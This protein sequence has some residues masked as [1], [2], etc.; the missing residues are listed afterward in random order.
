MKRD[1]YPNRRRPAYW[2]RRRGY[3]ALYRAGRAEI[4]ALAAAE[5]RNAIL[6]ELPEQ[7]Q[8]S[9][10]MSSDVLETLGRLQGRLME[11]AEE[12]RRR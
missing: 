1:R 5:R 7:G 6:G 4:A 8:T 2:V 3:A 12:T 11:S 10:V 9:A